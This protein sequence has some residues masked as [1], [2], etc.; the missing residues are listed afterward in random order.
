MVEFAKFRPITLILPSL[1]SEL[2]GPALPKIIQEISKV[3]YVN[4]IVIG[5]D[6]ANEKEFHEA[7]KFFSE[8]PQ[9]HE[10]LWNDGPNLKSLD[11]ILGKQNLAPQ[12]LG[13]GRN[14]WYCMGYILSVGKAEAVALHDCDIVTYSRSLL[15][16]LVYPVANPKFNFD[17]CKGYY[18]R[19]SENKV[20]GRVARLLVTPLLRALEKTIGFNEF[21]SF[22][23]SFRYPLAG[24]FSF[25]RR[26]LKDIRIPYDWGLEIGVLSEMFRNYAGN[27]LCQVDIADNY[28]HKHQD[29]FF[30]DNS[31][32][33]SKM[34]IDIIKV[35]IRKLASQG[36]P[37]SMSIF[38]SLKATYYRE[39]LDFVQIYKKDALMNAYDIDVHEEETAVE[40]FAK[41]IMV[42]GQVF[43]DSPME[44][45]N[46][47]TWSRVDTA[48]PGF[49]NDLRKAVEQDN[50]S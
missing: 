42:A 34:S 21:I 23:D 37:F 16:R 8:L 29:I 12:E 26:V 17:F 15:A 13:K 5:L 33:L 32:G 10:I 9:K 28:D 6:K 43:L 41:N 49:L 39:A 47:P 14:V 50:K 27:R 25:R 36:E 24:E 4:H 44:S 3:R 38:R 46:I 40:L 30:D 48:L 7:K 2:K 19:V 22:V 18:P 1:F 11:T 20:K 45:P 35:I 31:K